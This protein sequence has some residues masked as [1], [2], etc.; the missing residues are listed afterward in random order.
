MIVL[1]ISI[2]A[3]YVVVDRTISIPLRKLKNAAIEIGKG[4]SNLVIT[5]PST[6]DEIEELSSQFEK[7]R[8]RVKTRTE[9]LMRKDKELETASS[10]GFI[11]FSAWNRKS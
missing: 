6:V 9:E 11:C 8:V 10:A 4:N 5:P 3:I 1:S 7:M 2:F